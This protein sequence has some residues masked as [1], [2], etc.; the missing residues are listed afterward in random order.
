M[1]P[2][3][4]M[5]TD[6]SLVWTCKPSFQDLGT[7]AVVQSRGKIG[8]SQK[9]SLEL[10]FFRFSSAFPSFF[11]VF[12]PCYFSFRR[13]FRFVPF[14]SVLSVSCQKNKKRGDT[15]PFCETPCRAICG[16]DIF[17]KP[18][19]KIAISEKS[20]LLVHVLP[21]RIPMKCAKGKAY[22]CMEAILEVR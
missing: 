13:L 17:S 16:N 6:S 20:R 9:G 19:W 11:F 22:F 1:L 4:D 2:C 15:Y 5:G 14:S 3:R 12:F 8:I 18:R 21:M 10:F 7:W